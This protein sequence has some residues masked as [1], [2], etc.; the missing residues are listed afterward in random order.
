MDMP[1]SD[2]PDEETRSIP[3][4]IKTSLSR[5]PGVALMAALLQGCEMS[6]MGQRGG[7]DRLKPEG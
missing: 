2:Q 6:G 7:E 1:A 3:A 5:V 4:I